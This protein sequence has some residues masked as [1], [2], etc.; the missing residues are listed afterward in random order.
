LPALNGLFSQPIFGVIV[1]GAIAAVE[2]TRNGR[3]GVIGTQATLRSRAYDQAIHELEKNVEVHG[4]ACPLLVPLVEEG[5]VDHDVTAAVL[6]EYLE[7][8]LARKI[9]TLVLGCTH[10]PLLKAAIEQVTGPD[11]ALVDSAES[12]A[13]YVQRE[14]ERLGLLA[15]EGRG[16]MVLNVTDE[17]ERVTDMAERFLGHRPKKI[18]QV[19][20]AS[21]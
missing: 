19:V 8:L 13:Q 14:L 20:L 9:D 16:G 17:M 10:Y 3:I 11:I 12:C 6:R 21:L 5:W 2:A 7:P 18:A 1:P 15:S 4:Q